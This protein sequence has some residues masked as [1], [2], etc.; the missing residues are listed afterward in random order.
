M[1]ESKK[2]KWYMLAFMAFNS[3]WGF[4]NITNAFV[5]F[6]GTKVI[7]YWVVLFALYFVP[8]VL[9]VGELGSVFRSED[10]GVSSW[11]F[12]TRGAK[13]AY[14]AGWTYWACHVTYIAGKGS[15]TLKAVSWVVF[16]NA[17]TLDTLPSLYVQFISLAI[18]LTACFLVTRGINVLKKLLTVA[19]VCV[20]V[21]S[22]L[23]I[24]MMFLAPAVNPTAEYVNV[25]FSW[26]KILPDLGRVGSLSILVFGV[27]GSEK[28]SPYV[29]KVDRPSK[30]FPKA[31]ICLTVMVMTTAILGVFAMNRMFD[32]S[33]ITEENMDSYVANSAY[34]AFQRLGGY[35][36]LGDTLMIIYAASEAIAFFASL[37]LSIDAPL[38]ILLDNENTRQFIPK[39]FHQTNSK[40]VHIYG[41]AMVAVLSGS[42][43][44][45]QSFAPSAASIL[46]RLVKLNSVCMPLRYLWVFVAYVAMRRQI[47][48]FPAEY[49]FSKRQGIAKFFGFW[50][51]GVT[52]VCCASG[53]Y[54]DD[55]FTMTLNI[56]TPLFLTAL[57]MILPEIAKHERAKEIAPKGSE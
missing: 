21:M 9:M 47:E 43:V 18:L 35:Y 8:Y 37:V 5:Y 6:G 2:I 28:L 7:L 24:L 55:L 39:R 40:G 11:V 23:Y 51:F 3:V 22:L 16:R 17:E 54:S 33:L 52:A 34:W 27:G 45:I 20:F 46:Q 44:L 1:A 25:G 31:M 26:E 36:G 41:V 10:G 30:N 48:R 15:S 53:M 32:P 19:G 49:R 14:Y 57:G 13:I 56:L 4:G 38:R 42:I 29:N 50:C 12:R